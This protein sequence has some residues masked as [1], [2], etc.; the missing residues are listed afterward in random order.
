MNSNSEKLV[1]LTGRQT[2]SPQN[3]LPFKWFR[4]PRQPQ[5]TWEDGLGHC[6]WLLRPDWAWL[7]TV[8]DGN[9]TETVTEAPMS[10]PLLRAFFG[11]D[12]KTLENS[13]GR[14]WVLWWRC[15]WWRALWRRRAADWVSDH[16]DLIWSA[17]SGERK[18]SFPN[19][20]NFRLTTTCA[21]RAFLMQVLFLELKPA[22]ST[23]SF[24]SLELVFYHFFDQW[25]FN[26]DH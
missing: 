2:Q 25:N 8:G 14:R 3:P 26:L 12:S 13:N 16:S 18:E 4:H 15:W 20:P 1:A 9:D 7:A 6:R 19:E 23:K 5:Q 17:Q 21:L 11:G 24:N 22:T 10:S